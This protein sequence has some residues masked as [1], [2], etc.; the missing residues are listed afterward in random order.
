MVCTS[1]G[2]HQPTAFKASSISA[3][4]RS[5]A[6]SPAGFAKLFA[7]GKSGAAGPG[8]IGLLPVAPALN[9][10][11][12]PGLRGGGRAIARRSRMSPAVVQGAIL[13]TGSAE[14]TAGVGMGIEEARGGGGGASTASL[15][16]E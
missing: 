5:N 3:S 6:L 16:A 11:K 14:T 2:C 13:G 4:I 12:R 9:E 10:P 7:G 1:P 8:E 15:G